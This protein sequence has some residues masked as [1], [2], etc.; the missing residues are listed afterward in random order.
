MKGRR[1][2]QV[3]WLYP[4]TAIILAAVLSPAAPAQSGRIIPKPTPTPEA[5][6]PPKV[7]EPKFIPDP[8]AEKYRLVFATRFEGS[9]SYRDADELQ[10]A[11]R[12]AF[13]NFVE[14]LNRAGA[15]GYR[16]V[17]SLK[18]DPAI[19]ALDKYQF[20]YAWTET[21]SRVANLK[22]GF[23]GTYAQLAKKGFHLAAHA[24]LYGYCEPLDPDRCDYRDFFLFERR[25]GEEAPREHTSV[26]SERGGAW[27]KGAPHEDVLTTAV[28]A[29]LAE[30]FYPAHLLSKFEILLER[31]PPEPALAEAGTEVRV[32][33]SA[34]FWEHDELPKR[35]N[36]LARQGFRLAL[37]DNEIA[38][39]Y[40]RPGAATPL[41]YVWVKSSKKE[42]EKE[43]A[44]LQE[45]G[46]VFRA[47]YPDSDGTRRALIFEQGPSGDAARREYRV[48]RFEL[49]TRG[50]S[51]EQ[52]LETGLASA[53]AETQKELNRLAAEGF[54]VLAL[55][56]TDKYKFTKPG[57][58]REGL[59][60]E[61]FA[62]LLERKR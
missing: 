25:K 46:A 36:E 21:G 12:S 56:D 6:R 2:L 57:K 48:V 60:S 59:V 28:S 9:F 1:A 44:G 32:V 58:G 42:F 20:E 24:L 18:G 50:S 13:D 23:A 3:N 22:P 40:R 41:A 7:E 34:S 4:A 47:T 31:E 61:E 27:R 53:S 8:N 62:V 38:L 16:L 52:V 33:R 30:G 43:I 51:A 55:F 14:G 5:A 29:K 15:Q 54:V 49:Q 17:T 45:A 39:M 37:A 10:M 35:V 19:V 11:R 26:D